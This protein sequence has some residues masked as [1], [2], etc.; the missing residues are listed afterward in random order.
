MNKY[1]CFV[2]FNRNPL[3]KQ[4]S[5]R[6]LKKMCS[7]NMPHIYRRRPMPKCGFN[8]IACNSIEIELLHGCSPTNLYIFRTPFSKNTSGRELLPFI[9]HC[10]YI[11]SIYSNWTAQISSNATY[12]L[13]NS[14]WLISVYVTIPIWLFISLSD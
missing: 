13:L 2:S 1:W 14:L 7:G 11:V 5:R 4:P 6:V 8:K 12:A 10:S 9:F 3:Q